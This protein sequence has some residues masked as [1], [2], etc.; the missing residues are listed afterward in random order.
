MILSLKSRRR[1]MQLMGMSSTAV[2]L[3][4]LL[5]NQHLAIL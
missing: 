4:D 5:P 1:F 3:G 2:I